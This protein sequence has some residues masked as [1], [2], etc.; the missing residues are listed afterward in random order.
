M[1]KKSSHIIDSLFFPLLFI[2]IIWGI[3][4]VEIYYLIDFTRFGIIPKDSNNLFQIISFHFIHIDLTHLINNTYPILILG[5]IV[6]Y[7]YNKIDYQIYTLSLLFSG[8]ILWFIGRSDVIVVGASG[9]I[10]AL[11]SFI[12]TSGF[13]RRNPK[14]AILSF[15]VIFLYGSM[16]W[17]LFPQQNKVS[18]EGHL[19]GFIAGIIIAFLYKN[20]GPKRRKYQWE[21]D[22]ELEDEEHMVKVKY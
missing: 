16:F 19:S 7:F 9:F 1:K 20:Q 4:C 18:W 12:I 22:E 15:L 13:I 10:Y 3:K 17:G 14:L 11:A 5:C 21:I 8:I 2:I 6:S